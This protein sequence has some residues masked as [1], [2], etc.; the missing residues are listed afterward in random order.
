MTAFVG[1]SLDRVYTADDL[2][3]AEGYAAQLTAGHDT[4]RL[5]REVRTDIGL[6]LTNHIKRDDKHYVPFVKRT[7]EG[8]FVTRMLG[9][10][11]R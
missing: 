3:G 10:F 11:F 8:N 7:L 4:F 6:W 5:A 2:T 1:A 9:K